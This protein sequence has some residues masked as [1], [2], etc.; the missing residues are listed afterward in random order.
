[1]NSDNSQTTSAESATESNATRVGKRTNGW[2]GEDSASG[3]AGGVGNRHEAIGLD[4]GSHILQRHHG[5]HV[6]DVVGREKLADQLAVQ[7]DADPSLVHR[8]F[9]ELSFGN[10]GLR[11]LQLAG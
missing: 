2:C 11:R 3:S 9:P 5:N 1:M 4:D 10:S 6:R 7:L 8:R